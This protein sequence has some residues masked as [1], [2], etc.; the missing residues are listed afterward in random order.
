MSGQTFGTVFV[1]DGDPAVRDS[2][3]TLLSLNGFEVESYS[4]GAAFLKRLDGGA[5]MECVV[6]EEDLPDASGIEIFV[7]VR[8]VDAGTPFALLVSRRNPSIMQHARS[9]GI[10]RVFQKPLVHRHLIEFISTKSH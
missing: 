8:R 2:L 4:T 9:A 3:T 5:R 6:C 10:D 7:R 1:V